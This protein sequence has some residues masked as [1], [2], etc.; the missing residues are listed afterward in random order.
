MNINEGYCRVCWKKIR[1]KRYRQ[2]NKAQVSEYFKKWYKE[3]GRYKRRK[4]NFPI[5]NKKLYEMYMNRQRRHLSIDAIARIFQI[6]TVTAYQ[7]IK[8]EKD[9]QKKS[10]TN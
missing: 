9:K 10:S 2:Q 1:Q 5:R 8:K 4:K 6:S 7:I 3:K